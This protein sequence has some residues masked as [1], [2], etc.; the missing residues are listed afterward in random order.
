MSQSQSQNLPEVESLSYLHNGERDEACTA[1]GELR[2][3]WQYLLSS[4]RDLGPAGLDERTQKIGRILRDD[5]ASYNVAGGAAEWGL[6]PV[7]LLLQAAEW[8][9]VEQG[10]IERAQLLDLVLKDIYGSQDIIRKGLV[11]PEVIYSHPGFIRACHH[12]RLPGQ[13]QLILHAA[14]L[15]RAADNR[16]MVLGD[17]TQAPS[18]SGYALE[19]RIVMQRV[20]PMVFRNSRVLRMRQ[21]FNN[22]RLQMQRLAP[23]DNMQN[24][25]PPRVV[26]LTPGA[27]SETFFEHACLA[28][29]LGY[30]LVQGKDLTVRRGYVWMKTLD[31]LTRVDVIVRRVDDHYCDPV[32]LRGDSQLGVPGLLEVV[33]AGQ[34]VLANPLGSGILESGA[35][36]KY[37]PAISQYF[38]GHPLSLPSAPT[39]WCGDPDDRN[40]VLQ[41]LERL[42]IEHTHRQSDSSAVCGV[43]LSAEQRLQLVQKIQAQPLHY[44]AQ[45]YVQPSQ[46]P[47]WRNRALQARPLALRAFTV[48]TEASYLVMPG[49]L[50]RAA[51][52]AGDLLISNQLGAISKDTWVLSGEAAE[53]EAFSAAAIAEPYARVVDIGLPSRVAENLFWVGRYAKRSDMALR[54]LRTVFVQLNGA[55]MLP[56]EAERQLLF[57]VTQVTMTYPGF[58]EAGENLFNNPERELMSVVLDAERA[59]SITASLNAMLSSAAEVREML[60]SD[61]QRVMNDIQDGVQQLEATLSTGMASAPEEALDPLVTAMFALA[62]LFQESM[63]RGV[64]WHFLQLGRCIEKAYQ[65]ATLMRSL[66]VPVTGEET[67]A[68]CIESILQTSEALT[69][70]RRRFRADTRLYNALAMLLL[71]RS[72]PR[73][74]LY[75]LELM[76]GYLGNLPGMNTNMPQIS[77]EQRAVTEAIASVQLARLDDLVTANTDNPIRGELDQLLVRVQELMNTM[78]V[79]ISDRFFDHTDGPQQLVDNPW[80]MD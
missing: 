26:I 37:L 8:Q 34:V 61:T 33:R 40:Y 39:Y 23:P 31:G 19:N 7:P 69:I 68:I 45:D 16:W 2:D 27:Y 59:G 66:L 35:L 75:Q 18:G 78:A 79:A 55:H 29:Y 28:N 44:V 42:R 24:G 72:N 74:L 60:S 57:A 11:P 80:T 76:R 38:F 54:L 15:V 58:T 47:C 32:E 1:G 73:A 71:D 53:T 6:D 25:E 48:A 5:G 21:F 65:S 41:N 50:A 62:G 10:L 20:F 17:R 51:A 64:S 46:G 43:N 36:M 3:H 70:F 14:D 22:L 63:F 30:P 56:L 52:E 9:A 4:L 12:T 77:R 67:E 49:G 13:H